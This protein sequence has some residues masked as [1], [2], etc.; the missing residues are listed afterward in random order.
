MEESPRT[1]LSQPAL[2]KGNFTVSG[3]PADTF[4]DIEVS[5]H[6]DFS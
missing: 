1:V 5:M 3:K 6:F 4:L 2:F